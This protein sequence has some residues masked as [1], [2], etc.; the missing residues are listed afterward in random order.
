MDF[1]TEFH[2]LKQT[3][4][5][6]WTQVREPV[7][8]PHPALA[9]DVSAQKGN[10]LRVYKAIVQNAHLH[11]EHFRQATQRS[12][13]AILDA[14]LEAAAQHNL[15][16]AQSMARAM[17]ELN[18]LLHE[19][20]SRLNAIVLRVDEHNWLS[21]GESY[22]STIVRARFGTSNPIARAQLEQAGAA[23][24]ALKPFGITACLQKLSMVESFEDVEERYAILCDAVHHNFGSRVG[25]IGGIRVDNRAAVGAGTIVVPGNPVPIFRYEYPGATEILVRHVSGSLHGMLTDTRAC[26]A[27]LNQTP[28]TPFPMELTERITGNPLGSG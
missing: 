7:E 25:G 22:W 24:A 6:I 8:L 21:L 23:K 14:Y 20:Q 16:V 5:L 12:H 19:I 1:G 27:W 17:L 3:R 9:F 18:G 4:D 26:I 10:P 28:P 15:I 11:A 13:L 2:E